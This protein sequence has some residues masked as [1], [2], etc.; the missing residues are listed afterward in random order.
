MI[1]SLFNSSV[2]LLDIFVFIH[3]FKMLI[4]FD[5]I[6]LSFLG[7]RFFLVRFFAGRPSSSAGRTAPPLDRLAPDHPSPDLS[8]QDRSSPDPHST[9]KT[10]RERRRDDIRGGRGQKKNAK[11]LPALFLGLGPYLP[12]F[13]IFLFLY[14]FPFVFLFLFIF[15]IFF[16]FGFFDFSLSLIFRLNIFFVFNHVLFYAGVL[17]N[18]AL[19][20]CPF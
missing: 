6:N 10:P 17:S 20:L 8:S 14:I 4:F 1:F 16:I 12:H 19:C 3:F 5:L 9:K 13:F 11:C 7:E 15:L 18:R 2:F